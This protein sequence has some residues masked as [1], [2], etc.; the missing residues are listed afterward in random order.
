MKIDDILYLLDDAN[1][2][3]L[4]NIN[5]AIFEELGQPF[6]KIYPVDNFN[7]MKFRASYYFIDEKKNVHYWNNFETEINLQCNIAEILHLFPSLIDLV[8]RYLQPTG[9]KSTTGPIV[10]P[11][12]Q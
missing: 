11:A 4:V 12:N 6:E 1:L 9:R 10:G 3:T 8:K 2:Q 7:D 5:N